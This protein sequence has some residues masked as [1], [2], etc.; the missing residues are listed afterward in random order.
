MPTAPGTLIRNSA[1]RITA[2]FIIDDL[3]Y[4]FSATVSPSI[5]PFTSQTATVEYS[6]PDD[7]TSTRSYSGNIGTDTFK[8]TLHNG[9]T[10]KG[11]LNPPGVF[12][13]STVDGTGV[14][15]QN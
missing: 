4:S 2:L 12:P 9:P 10:L 6:N 5:Q 3:Q 1:S 14:W 7:L 11:Q 13:A 15:E 8:L